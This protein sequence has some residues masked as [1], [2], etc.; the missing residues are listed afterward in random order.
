MR[1]AADAGF[2]LAEL[3]IVIVVVSVAAFLF[4][5]MFVEA[6]RSYQFVDA[7]KGMLQEARYAEERVTREL[8]RVRDKTSVTEATPRAFGF[9]D[10]D[11]AAI[12]VS[13]TGTK[14]DPLLYAKNG[15]AQVLCAGVDSMAFAYWKADGTP[16]APVVAPSP[17]DV[18][19]VTLYLRLGSAGHTVSALTGAFV[20]SL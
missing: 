13:W 6:V 15:A 12:R 10:R 11:A 19:R 2:S 5:G 3:T 16:A 7:E 17:T 18:W 1:A 8:K 9:V 14:G 20:R 4:S